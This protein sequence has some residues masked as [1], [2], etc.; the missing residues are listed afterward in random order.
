GLTMSVVV[1]TFRPALV[2][3]GEPA[4]RKLS[5]AVIATGARL[6]R[7]EDVVGYMGDLFYGIC[8]PHT[9]KPGAEVVAGRILRELNAMGPALGVAVFP[10]DGTGAAAPLLAARADAVRRGWRSDATWRWNEAAL[11]P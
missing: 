6:L 11:L 7:S 10:E 1:I 3:D 2:E 4:W 9:N 8:L 5:Q